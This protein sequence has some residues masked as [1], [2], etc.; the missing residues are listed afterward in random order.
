[1]K[2]K[3]AI[4]VVLV[5]IAFSITLI[6][7]SVAKKGS[8]KTFT[9]VEEFGKWLSAQ[10]DNTF[11]TPYSVVLNISDFGG[12]VNTVGSLG[13]IL[14]INNSKYV[15]LNLS[16]S[17]ITAIPDDAFDNSDNSSVLSGTL[18][19]I[20]LPDSVTSIGQFAFANCNNLSGIII[21]P[22][23]VT[24]IGQ[25]AFSGCG[26]LD[27]VTIGN[28]VTSIGD[29]AFANCTLTRVSIPDSVTNMGGGVFFNCKRLTDV[30][31]G[32][33]V[34][35][36]IDGNREGGLLGR[37][38][39]S[40]TFQGCNNLTSVTIGNNV[41]NIEYFT[42]WDCT[43]LASI[44]IPDKVTNIDDGVFI[45]CSNLTAINVNVDNTA[46]SSDNGILY[47]K[48]KTLLVRY[49][50]G[51]TGAFSIPAGVTGIADR[52]FAYSSNLTSITIPNS[53]ISIG[54]QA[55]SDC[56]R[57]TSVTIP[58]SVI[59]IGGLAFDKCYSLTSVTIE[60]KISADNFGGG[61]VVALDMFDNSNEFYSLKYEYPFDDDLNRKYLAANGGPGT[62]TRAIIGIWT[63]DNRFT[64]DNGFTDRKFRNFTTEE[65]AE[66]LE[67]L[68]AGKLSKEA[69]ID[70]QIELFMKMVFELM[71]DEPMSNDE[72]NLLNQLEKWSAEN[73]Q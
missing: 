21:I 66:L 4:V 12:D 37:S 65:I 29:F 68:N 50:K 56:N 51:K 45:D 30:I 63:K 43:S 3:I 20:I 72:K 55:F 14:S 5:L 25:Y 26:F 16:G 49:P 46:Y 31:I 9:S 27:N 36:I 10:R 32:N 53:V 71:V 33:G 15:S 24:D 58:N 19:G 47:N 52:A 11:N 69:I 6:T 2:S 18:T 59:S 28:N 61:N 41:T 35:S 70:L 17:T 42:F 40:G 23:S 1:M 62:Y 67:M 22:D 57:L 34:T 60:G 44:T 73:N 39:I 13:F 48:T 38:V 7:F 54:S 8:A 64:E